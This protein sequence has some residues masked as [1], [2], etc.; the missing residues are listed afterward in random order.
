MAPQN[1]NGTARMIDIGSLT[2]IRIL[3]SLKPFGGPTPGVTFPGENRRP[4]T[5][6]SVKRCSWPSRFTR[7]R[8]VLLALKQTGGWWVN[9]TRLPFV[10]W[11]MMVLS[12]TPTTMQSTTGLNGVSLSEIPVASH[13]GRG[14]PSHPAQE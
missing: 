10:R 14:S 3:E 2:D 12:E 6:T 4:H 9:G 8:G 1:L 11:A 7:W 13:R 5:K